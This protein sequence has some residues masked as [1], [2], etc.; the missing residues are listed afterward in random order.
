M[1]EC[2]GN[3]L[4][5]HKFSFLSGFSLTLKFEM[6]KKVKMWCCTGVWLYPPFTLCILQIVEEGKNYLCNYLQ[7]EKV[8]SRKGK[9][10][11]NSL[12][13]KNWQEFHKT[14]LQC[15]RVS[16]GIFFP[17]PLL[18]LGVAQ[19]MYNRF[20]KECFKR[21]W[22]LCWKCTILHDWIWFIKE[23]ALLLLG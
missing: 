14:W 16:Y 3:N 23:Q 1:A 6:P 8:R 2:V 19:Y 12:M 7:R 13:H 11:F 17:P 22:I 15:S 5:S 20:S 4:A 10:P 9:Y 21:F 18:I